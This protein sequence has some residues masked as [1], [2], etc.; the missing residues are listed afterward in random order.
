MVPNKDELR[1]GLPGLIFRAEFTFDS[2]TAQF[3]GD[4]KCFGP[5]NMKIEHFS[6]IFWA[7]ESAGFRGSLEVLVGLLA[8]SE[9]VLLWYI[10][11]SWNGIEN[12]RFFN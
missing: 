5:R 3:W 2:H 12:F 8:R 9:S 10:G 6:L 4:P 1:C 11:L 7:I